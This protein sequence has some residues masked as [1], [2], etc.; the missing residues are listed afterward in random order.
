[1]EKS[2]KYELDLDPRS[3]WNMISA[4][5]NAKANLLYMQEVGD[6][7]A[8]K[9]YFT[10]REGFDSYL[11]KITVSG[12]GGRDEIDAPVRP[13]STNRAKSR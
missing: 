13:D 1:M 7:I 3:R 10:T 8:G 5:M 2:L 6:F 12:C 9:K 11:I 4:T